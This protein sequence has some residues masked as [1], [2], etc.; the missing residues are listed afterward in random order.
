MKTEKELN[1]ELKNL[2]DIY[3]NVRILH[4]N[5]KYLSNP[6]TDQEN[7]IKKEYIIF[8][9]IIFS[10]WR[11][12]IIELCKLFGK[13]ND[14][15]RIEAFLKD[16]ETLSY[17]GKIE[18][19]HIVDWLSTISNNVD[20]KNLIQKIQTLR[21]KWF[22]HSDKNHE[23]SI[24]DFELTK[25]EFDQLF[26]FIE[27]IIEYFEIKIYGRCSDFNIV[28]VNAIYILRD[29]VDCKRLRLLEHENAIK[30]QNR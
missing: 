20:L 16:F 11:L 22:A 14:H 2:K 24:C 18:K 15:Y 27:N 8:Q 12:T 30:D 6:K 3:I 26:S 9:S 17:K 21:D 5:C 19:S 28:D 25:I 7:E 1:I 10:M 4:D 13:S 29:L 23:K